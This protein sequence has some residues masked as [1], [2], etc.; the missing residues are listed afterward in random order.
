ME[1]YCSGA[2]RIRHRVTGE[3]HEIESDELN[4]DAVGGDERQMGPETHYE[5]VLE[6][7]ELGE[8]T[9]GIWEYPL[10]IENYSSTDVGDHE[11]VEDLDYG[12]KHEQPDTEEWLDYDVPA[13][14]FTVFMSSYHHTGDLM[15]D[16]GKEDGRY[17]V[18]RL[19]FSHQITALEAYLGDTLMNAV[20]TNTDALQRLVDADEEL[21]K[22]RFTLAEIRKEPGLV[23]RKVREHL[24]TTLYHNLA[25]VDVL[26]GIAFGVRILHLTDKKA[27]LFHAVMLRHDCVHR[28]G[29]NKDG[30]ELSTFSPDFVRGTA[31]IIRRLVESIERAI[32]ERKLG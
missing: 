30:Q 2:A 18:N 32:R 25:K 31:D 27:E 5:A 4:W 9:W 8:L 7:P 6:H 20:A 14:P 12:L 22:Q 29:F 28:N 15:A 17:L 10:G 1:V 26:Y 13:D 16:L 24:R 3:I 23:E 21:G 19:I 11:I